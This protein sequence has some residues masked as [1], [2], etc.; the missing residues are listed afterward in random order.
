MREREKGWIGNWDRT[1][2]GEGT[3]VREGEGENGGAGEGKD[4]GT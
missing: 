4:V 1:G 3:G 2:E